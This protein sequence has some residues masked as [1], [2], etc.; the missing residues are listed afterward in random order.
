MENPKEVFLIF[1]FYLNVSVLN[2]LSEYTV[3][4]RISIRGAHL[5]W[6]LKGECLFEGGALLRETL[7]K[8]IK[9]ITTKIKFIKKIT[10]FQQITFNLSL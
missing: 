4:T 9:K 10:T 3:F 1:V 2:K 8:F 7:I 6:V 5:I